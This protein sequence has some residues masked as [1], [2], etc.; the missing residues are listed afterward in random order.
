MGKLVDLTGQSFGRWTVLNREGKKGGFVSWL[1]RC[2]CGKRNVVASNSLR[3]GNSKSCGCYTLEKITTHGKNKN[4]VIAPE[5]KT[6]HM[7]VQRC[8]NPNNDG[9]GDYGGRGIK[10]CDRWLNF[11]D[12][13][14]DMGD[15]PSLKYS[16]DRIDNNGNYE[17]SNCRWA[18]QTDQSRNQRLR[19]DNTSGHKGIRWE[20]RRSKWRTYIN[21]NGKQ[22]F[23]GHFDSLPEAVDARKQ[24]EIKYWNTAS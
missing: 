19:I 2:E 4:Y 17:P 13:Y 20:S 3:T 18:T 8:T 7:M 1:C 22:I 23:I 14:A 15:R 16:L 10:V 12:F 9:Y 6:W 24:A 5:Y 21:V 11:E